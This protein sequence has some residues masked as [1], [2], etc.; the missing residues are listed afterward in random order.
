MATN[1]ANIEKGFAKIK[2]QI[3]AK[4]EQRLR[5]WCVEL[6]TTAIRMRL[7]D[8]NAHNFTGNLL[9]S[10]V[11]CLYKDGDPLDVFYAAGREGVKSARMP[12]MTAR[13]KP[14]FFARGD[15]DGA[16]SYF[17]ATIET[18][19]GWGVDDARA[20]FTSFRPDGRNMFDIVVAY[21]TEYA[22]FVQMARNTTGILETLGYARHTGTTFME[23]TSAA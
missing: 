1:S 15:Y 9:N 11:V 8:P 17:T 21:T 18:N 7:G 16:N 2:E 3:Y 12:K 4:T 23:L 20:F 13:T 14:Y 22:E 5:K 10:I 6:V 19:K